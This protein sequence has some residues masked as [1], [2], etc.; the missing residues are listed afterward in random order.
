MNF[1]ITTLLENWKLT[2]LLV[3]NGK[4]MSRGRV[5]LTGVGGYLWCGIGYLAPKRWSQALLYFGSLPA[6]VALYIGLSSP[7]NNHLTPGLGT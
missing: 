3:M 5:G 7:A 1:S 4:F 2:N 6:I